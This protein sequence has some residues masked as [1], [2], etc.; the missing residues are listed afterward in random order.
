MATEVSILLTKKE[1]PNLHI[2]VDSHHDLNGHSTKNIITS[3]PLTISTDDKPP[4]LRTIDPPLILED[5]PVDEHPSIKA[6]VVGGGITGI[7]AGILLPAK[8]PGLELTI[9]ERYS[10]IVCLGVRSTGVL[11]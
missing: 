9:Y 7:T 6:I 8:V 4:P 2:E 10:D 1:D 11:Y 3:E 5:H